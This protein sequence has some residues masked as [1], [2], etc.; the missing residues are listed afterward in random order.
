[1]NDGKKVLLSVVTEKQKNRQAHIML[2]IPYRYSFAVM[3]EQQLSIITFERFTASI[4][5]CKDGTWVCEDG[6]G[7]EM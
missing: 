2:N 6:Q 4:G 5:M 7:W 1:M 3:K